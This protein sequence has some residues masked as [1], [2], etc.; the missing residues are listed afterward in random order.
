MSA[1]ER[2][3]TFTVR[4]RAWLERLLPEL[5]RGGAFVAVGLAHLVGEG[6]LLA[7]LRA[8]GLVIERVTGDGGLAVP[9]A[10][11]SAWSRAPRRLVP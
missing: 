8:E 11:G 6:S 3:A 1:A 9:E 10:A 2:H 5:R 4:N 7:L